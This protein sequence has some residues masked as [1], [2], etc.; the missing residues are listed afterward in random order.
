MITITESAATKIQGL[1]EEKGVADH[2]V[3]LYIAGGGCSGVQYGMAFVDDY[4]EVDSIF[5][6]NGLKV[7]V[8]PMSIQYLDGATVDFQDEMFHIDNPNPNAS[9]SCAGCGSSSHCS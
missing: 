1:M 4:A 2:H 6:Q 3:R 5:E 7:V 9:P 8:D